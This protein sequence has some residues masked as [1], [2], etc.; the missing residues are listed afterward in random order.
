MEHRTSPSGTVLVCANL[1]RGLIPA[2]LKALAE[3]GTPA[4]YE[5]L[6]PTQGTRAPKYDRR[7]VSAVAKLR[8]EAVAAIPHRRPRRFKWK[9]PSHGGDGTLASLDFL[10]RMNQCEVYCGKVRLAAE[11]RRCISS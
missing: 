8:P 7:P 9:G 10:E 11:L 3:S 6:L 4:D 1:M 2:A 5:S